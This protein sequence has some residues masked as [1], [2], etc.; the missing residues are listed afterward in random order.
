MRG[1]RENE[2]LGTLPKKLKGGSPV[3]ACLG[4]NRSKLERRGAWIL[5]SGWPFK[6]G[7]RIG[8]IDFAHGEEGAGQESRRGQM[9]AL[10]AGQRRELDLKSEDERSH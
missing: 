3:Q 6:D 1:V 10:E 2:E 9:N 7:D 8:A 5:S 4:S